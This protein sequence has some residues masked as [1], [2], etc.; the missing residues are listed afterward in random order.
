MINRRTMLAALPASTFA[1]GAA[2]SSAP[3]DPVVSLY[4][5]W[6]AAR[7]EWNALSNMPGN[8]D[9]DWPESIAAEDRAFELMF[10]M[11]ELTP[12]TIEGIAA[13][14][15]ILWD[16]EGPAL[17]PDQPEYDEEMTE[18]GNKA[19]FAIWRAASSQAGPPSIS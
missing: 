9:F 8:E 7:A 16:L 17:R 2:A 10:K 15:H 1:L 18:P 14:M 19:M 6:L 4:R 13:M 11:V 5:E 12:T 3:V